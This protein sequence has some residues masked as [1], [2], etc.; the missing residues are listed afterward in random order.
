MPNQPHA[1]IARIIA[2]RFEPIVPNA[3]RAKTGK[4]NAVLRPGCELSRIGIEHDRV[5]EQDR[6]HRL[7]PVHAGV[8]QTR[9]RACRSGCSAPCR[10]RAPR[11]FQVDQVRLFDRASARDRRFQSGLCETSVCSSTKSRSVGG[12]FRVVILLIVIPRIAAYLRIESSM[13]FVTSACSFVS[14]FSSMYIMCPA[15]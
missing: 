6:D 8:D 10:S 1:T 4:R 9:R 11:M 7:P 5:A 13:N 2:G 14:D 15:S 3:A 12:G